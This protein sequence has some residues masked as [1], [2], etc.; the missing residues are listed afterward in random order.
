M[1]DSKIFRPPVNE[2]DISCSRSMDNV[3]ANFINHNQTFNTLG[4]NEGGVK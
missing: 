1:T 4:D 3:T 2:D